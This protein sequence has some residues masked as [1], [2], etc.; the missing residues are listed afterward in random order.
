MLLPIDANSPT[1]LYIQLYEILKHKIQQQEFNTHEKLPS[2]RSLAQ[3]NSIS[4]NTVTSAYEQLLVEG[5]IYSIERKGYYVS[6]IE[7]HTPPIH[8]KNKG[9]QSAD[10]AQE[11]VH[12]KY[13]YN[14]T[15]SNP[16]QT[17]FPFATF[18]KLYRQLLQAEDEK[19][20]RETSGQGLSPLRKQLQQYLSVSRGVPCT[21]DQIILGPSTEFLLGILF[22]LLS[23]GLVVGIEDPGYQ[24]FQQLLKRA[25]IPFFPVPV[26]NEG[27]SVDEL[28]NSSI[29]LMFATSNHQFPTGTIM[30][31]KQ[32]QALLHWANK[33]DQRYIVEND[34]D[35][36]FK[37]SGIPIPSLKY[38]DQNNRVIHIGSFTRVL[39]PGIR[40]SYMVLPNELV[41]I[42]KKSF[43]AASSA[44]SSFEQWLIHDFIEAGHFSTHLNRSRTFYKKKRDQMIRAIQKN[45]PT[46]KIF[47]E[48]AGLHLLV[49]PS[50]DFDGPRFK[51]MA[52]DKKIKL[53]LLSD[54]SFQKKQIQDQT[55]FLSFSSIPERN[56]NEVVD[57]LFTLIR[58]TTKK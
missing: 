36:E 32:R 52:A 26:T 49:Q 43:S 10:E 27:L 16:D 37:Y 30:P 46:A 15:R 3:M 51:D 20:I 4:E 12:K 22:D 50:F 24:G 9:K 25:K 1:A 5:Y 48:K 6:N 7:F 28:Q 45:D 44:L 33:A 39:S 35:S 17:I 8:P 53:N 31:L 47:G 29:N 23:E 21:T 2:K 58:L 57:N 38:L 41:K 11:A 54:Y 19:L 34:Y 55:I 56:I 40:L 42:Y 18:L 13:L 14:F